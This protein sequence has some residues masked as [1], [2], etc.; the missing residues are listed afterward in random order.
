MEEMCE[1]FPE[2]PYIH[3]GGDEANIKAWNS[4][5]Q[6]KD[7]MKKNGIGDV[8]ELYS[9]FVGRMAKL[10]LDMGKT[11]SA[12]P[13]ILLR[14]RYRDRGKGDK[15]QSILITKGEHHEI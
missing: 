13:D 8:Y 10:T 2:A 5:P 11:P 3:I 12:Y 7:Y 4:C 1:L 9:E 15:P 14:Y 6:C